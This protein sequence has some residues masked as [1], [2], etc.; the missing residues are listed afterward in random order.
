MNSTNNTIVIDAMGGDHAPEEI[1]KGANQAKSLFKGLNLCLVGKQ[2]EIEKALSSLGLKSDGI[3]II[4]ALQNISMDE[5]PSEIV[6][7]KKESP[8][9]K[10]TG[11]AAEKGNSAFLSAGNTGAV[12][13]CS[14]FNLK[15]VKNVLRPAIATVIPLAE[16]KLVLIDSGANADCKPKYLKQFAIMGKV[17]AE[18]ILKISNPKIGLINVGEEEK[19]GNKLSIESYKLLKET[20]LNFIGNI[21]GRD[22]FEGIADVAVCDGFVGNILLKAVEGLAGLLFGQVKETLT[23]NIFNKLLALG[24]KN[25]F[26]EMKKKFD[27]EEYGGAHLLGLNEVVIISHGS[28]KAKAIRNAIKVANEG[29]NSNL[30]EKIREEIISN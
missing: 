2:T 19:K 24:L 5:S 12:M 15:R 18:N 14:L 6:R 3:E 10:G 21:E 16:K 13:A 7:K 20:K 27:Y 30:V 8:I 26:K 28:S 11:I 29:I 4:D 1:L 17:Y 25:S 9:Y 22:M 23:K